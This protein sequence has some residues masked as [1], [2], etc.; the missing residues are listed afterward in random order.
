MSRHRWT[1]LTSLEV[2]M[3]LHIQIDTKLHEWELECKRT[4]PSSHSY[5]KLTLQAQV[6]SALVKPYQLAQ[7]SPTY[8]QEN[9]NIE[10]GRS[11]LLWWKSRECGNT[12]C[13]PPHSRR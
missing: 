7:D 1:L 6:S 9:E 10:D 3:D 5:P 12:S 13:Q 2:F 4:S 11:Q 8:S